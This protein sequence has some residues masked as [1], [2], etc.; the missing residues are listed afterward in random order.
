MP[1]SKGLFLASHAVDV[2][3]NGAA[4]GYLE[5]HGR[6]VRIIVGRPVSFDVA[7]NGCEIALSIYD[8]TESETVIPRFKVLNVCSR[9][10]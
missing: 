10:E 3:G 6:L 8:K 5:K 1:T 9:G 4:G 2:R 7:L